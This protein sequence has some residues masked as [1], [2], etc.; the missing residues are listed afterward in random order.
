MNTSIFVIKT[1]KRDSQ[2]LNYTMK[3]KVLAENS[4]VSC[5][6]NIT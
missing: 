1:G 2:K 3:F 4:K 6:K 5:S